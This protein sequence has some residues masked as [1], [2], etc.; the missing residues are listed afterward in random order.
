MKTLS[1]VFGLFY[2]YWYTCTNIPRLAT[3]SLLFLSLVLEVILKN[4]KSTRLLTEFSDDSTRSTNS[5]LDGTVL[6]ELGESAHSSKVLSSI[7]HDD[8]NLTLSTESTDELLVLFVLAIL[9]KT[10]KTSGTA[11]ESLSTLMK[12][13]LEAIMDECLLEDLQF[14]EESWRFSS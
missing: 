2:K 5:L 3:N 12:S 7:N 10:T 1:A 14:M 6:I 8:G 13:L 11:V 9:S 4:S